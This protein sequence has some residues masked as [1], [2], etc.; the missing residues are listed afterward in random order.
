MLHS[1][2]HF[3]PDDFRRE[4]AV[5][6]LAFLEEKDIHAQVW[7][8]HYG[9]ENRHNMGIMWETQQGDNPQ[10][11]AYHCDLTK[12]Y[13]I[14]YLWSSN[15]TDCIGQNGR[16]DFYNLRTLVYEFLLDLRYRPLRNRNHTNQLMNVV[17]LDDGTKMFDFV[18]YPLSYTG[19]G[20]GYQWAGDL[21]AQLSDEVLDKLIANKGY[22]IYYVH[23]GANDGPP[24]Y[25]S[26]PTKAALKNIA[27]R[28]HEGVLWVAPTT[29]ILRYHTAHKYLRWRHE[30]KENGTVSIAIDSTSNSVDG[31]YLPTPDQLKGITFKLKASKTCTVYL[32]GKMLAVDIRR[33]DAPARTTATL[34][35]EWAERR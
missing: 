13:G 14:K 6:A 17:S 33:N 29:R 35:G 30:I 20:T 19:H 3:G 16:M 28:Y 22:I 23:L 7:V 2:G 32:D 24:E 12:R 25:F 9:G 34:T 27:D 26:K 5:D 31:K 8:N 11:K 21:P 10:S 4:L 15:L 1:F 18:R